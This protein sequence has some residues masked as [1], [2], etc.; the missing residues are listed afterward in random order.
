ML[1]L[2]AVAGYG[3]AYQ[4]ALNARFV[5]HVPASHRARAFG[6]AVAGMMVSMGVTT[7]TAGALADVWTDPALTVGLCGVT[8]VAALAAIVRRWST[9][10]TAEDQPTWTGR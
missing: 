7:A 4:I 8:G 6:V 9:V 2:L 3:S 10:F 5:Q 1:V